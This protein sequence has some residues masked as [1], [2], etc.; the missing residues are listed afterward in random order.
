MLVKDFKDEDVKA[1]DVHSIRF[2]SSLNVAVDY[3][4]YYANGRHKR[5]NTTVLEEPH[6]DFMNS[7][8]DMQHLAQTIIELPLQNENGYD[9][10]LNIKSI[11]FLESEVYGD[12]VKFKLAVEGMT[13]SKDP[14]IIN[15]PS[16]FT[17]A[18]HRIRNIATGEDFPLQEL[19][20]LQLSK[21]TMMAV[22]A[23][24]LVYYNKR[25]QPTLD[26][27][28]KAAENGGYADELVEKEAELDGQGKKPET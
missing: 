15:S 7:L 10:I 6:E 1:F 3:D 22:E 13:N 27:A 24:K 5:Q 21:L 14:V 17:S 23:V 20:A 28:A 8:I 11:S 9:C 4:V 12:G 16:Y 26:E 19:D 2:G 25:K 18:P